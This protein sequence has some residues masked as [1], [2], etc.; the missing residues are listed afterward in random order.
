MGREGKC[1]GGESEDIPLDANDKDKLGLS[2]DVVA[3]VLLGQ[4]G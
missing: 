3:A 2:R 4:A 1:R